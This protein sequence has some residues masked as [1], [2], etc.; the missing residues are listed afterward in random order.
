MIVGSV[1]QNIFGIFKVSEIMYMVVGFYFCYKNSE[2][3]PFQDLSDKKTLKLSDVS[4]VTMLTRI[5]IFSF[6]FKNLTYDIKIHPSIF[7]FS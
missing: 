5:E 1:T 6:C 3:L 2:F 4:P 7:L